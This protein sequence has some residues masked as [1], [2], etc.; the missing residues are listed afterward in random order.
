MLNSDPIRHCL[1]APQAALGTPSPERDLASHAANLLS[2]VR[3]LSPRL[4][5]Q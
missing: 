5:S 1:E 4:S 3:R 2:P